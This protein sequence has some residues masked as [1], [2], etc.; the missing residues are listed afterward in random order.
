LQ[1]CLLLSRASQATPVSRPAHFF[2]QST[3]SHSGHSPAGLVHTPHRPV[4]VQPPCFVQRASRLPPLTDLLALTS[5]STVVW[6]RPTSDPI[7]R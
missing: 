7:S 1:T 5:R 4:T 2:L 6:L 3:S